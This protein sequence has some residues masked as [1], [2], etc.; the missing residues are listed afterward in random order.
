MGHHQGHRNAQVSPQNDWSRTRPTRLPCSRVLCAPD[1]VP[2]LLHL[3]IDIA[4]QDPPEELNVAD[5]GGDETKYALMP[6]HIPWM[7][8][9]D[10]P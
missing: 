3:L 5:F 6:V 7:L 2:F 10:M 4:I 1:V 8:M 9:F